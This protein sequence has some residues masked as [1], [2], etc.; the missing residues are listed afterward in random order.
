MWCR[1]VVGFN[2]TPEASADQL[3]SSTLYVQPDVERQSSEHVWIEM[4]ARKLNLTQGNP[5]DNRCS[6]YS[7]LLIIPAL[8]LKRPI[9]RSHGC[10]VA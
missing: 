10:Q 2:A 3:G 4:D 7:I 6:Q 1:H 5:Y 8:S 9:T